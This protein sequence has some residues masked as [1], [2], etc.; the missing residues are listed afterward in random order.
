[1]FDYASAY[2][3][4]TESFSSRY[5]RAD[6]GTTYPLKQAET[7]YYFLTGNA[8]F[9]MYQ[10]IR[11][12]ENGAFIRLARAELSYHLGNALKNSL[13]LERLTLFLRGEN[14]LLLSR[15][16]GYNPEENLNGIRRTDL[17]LTGTPLP[18]TV[19]MGLKLVL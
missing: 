1:M 18:A 14:L 7:P 6:I 10:G 4:V 3:I 15:Y 19:V 11:T 13:S 5:N 17:S 16:S 9:R 2:D 8:P 12:V